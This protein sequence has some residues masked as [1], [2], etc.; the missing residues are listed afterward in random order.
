VVPVFVTSGRNMASTISTRVSG[1]AAV[2]IMN[3]AG[4]S[5]G[6]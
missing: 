4:V 6:I 3:Q 2:I 5:R 1:F